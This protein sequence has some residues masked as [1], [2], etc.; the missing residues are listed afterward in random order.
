MGRKT[1]EVAGGHGGGTPGVRTVVVSRTLRPDEHP[2]ATVI[3]E[4]VEAAV[5]ELRAEPGRDIW[6]FGGGVLF[7]SLLK[8]GLVDTV[9][10]GVIPVLLGGGVPLLPPPVARSPLTLTAH[11]AYKSGIISLEYA[12]APPRKNRQ[13]RARATRK[14]RV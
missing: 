14:R 9:E 6:L 13:T 7:A 1:Y 8:A 12:V 11:R 2:S 10:V 5:A 4:N 3:G